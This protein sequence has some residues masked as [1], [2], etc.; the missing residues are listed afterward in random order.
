MDVSIVTAPY[1]VFS[2][3][4]DHHP[5]TYRTVE[6]RRQLID[7]ARAADDRGEL[8]DRNY[9]LIDS[10]VDFGTA[11]PGQLLPGPLEW[12]I[13]AF[14]WPFDKGGGPWKSESH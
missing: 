10:L 5:E 7:A 8:S 11:W 9:N 6:G 13:V 12:V 4:L 3:F 1:A 2:S 14:C